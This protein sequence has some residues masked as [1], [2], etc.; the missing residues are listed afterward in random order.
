[1][2]GSGQPRPFLEPDQ[3]MSSEALPGLILQM[4]QPI[5]K[6]ESPPGTVHDWTLFGF[7]GAGSF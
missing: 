7:L 3:C 2:H 4:D 1:M 6:L 5:T